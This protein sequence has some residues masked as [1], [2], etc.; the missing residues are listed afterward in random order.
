VWGFHKAIDEFGG[1]WLSAS[2]ELRIGRAVHQGERPCKWAR[3]LAARMVIDEGCC[4]LFII[5]AFCNARPCSCRCCALA[6]EVQQPGAH[7]RKRP[8]QRMQR[9][10]KDQP[11]LR[12]PLQ[13]YKCRVR[14]RG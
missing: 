3:G 2:V 7:A 11:C 14:G 1:S 8:G 12:K 13:F 10:Q 9:R 4:P 5:H 6:L